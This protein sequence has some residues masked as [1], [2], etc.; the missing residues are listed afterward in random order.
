VSDSAEWDVAVIGAGP[1]GLAAANASALAGAR[2]VVLERAEH[3]RY[4]TCGGGLIGTSLA[5]VPGMP[6]PVKDEIFAA[7]FT[8]NNGHEFTRRHDS[9][10]LKMVM[11][12]EFDDAL[13]CR[14]VANGA[15]LL[16]RAQVRAVSQDQMY[17]RATLAD[18]T[19]VT[20]QVVVGADGSSGITARHV[21]VVFCQVDLGLEVEISVPA[22]TRQV[23]RGRVLLDWGPVPGSYAWVFPKDDTLTVGVIAARG[24][25]EQTKGYL[26]D[27]LHHH[28]LASFER[29]HDSGHLTK[30]RTEGSPLRK[31]RVLA[32]GDAAGLLEPWTREGISFALRSG[33]MAGAAAAK[34]ARQHGPENPD[35]ILDQY[36]SAVSSGL[37]PEMQAGHRLL[38]AFK[39]HPGSFHRALATPKGWHT[40]VEFCQGE[41][42]FASALQHKSAALA[43]YLLSKL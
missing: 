33:A 7:T 20:A 21:G 37:V 42:S 31:G 23:W 40:F 43:I 8:R 10:I 28:N 16:Q 35:Q 27:I 32:A 6:I 3:P 15:V 11:R 34:A 38:A 39:R 18:G 22:S 2:T 26:Q 1:A 19:S 30:C 24:S 25:G 4:K 29:L 13:R 14:A 17:A 9:P 36:V 12:D 41:K 5:A